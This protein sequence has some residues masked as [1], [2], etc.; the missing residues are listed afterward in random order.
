[1]HKQK[2]EKNKRLTKFLKS[3]DKD[4][5]DEKGSAKTVTEEISIYGSLCRKN[6]PIDA[7]AFWKTHGEQLPLLKEMAQTYLSTPGTS[8]PSESAFSLSAYVGRKERARLS[9]ENLSYSIFFTV[10]CKTL[11]LRREGGG[12]Y[13]VS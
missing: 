1:M 2:N 10:N 12:G 13:E 5:Q 9:P 8:V 4:V 11:I 7:I 6:P 3:I